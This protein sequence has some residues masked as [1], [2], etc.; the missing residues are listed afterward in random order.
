LV[1]MSGSLQLK[2]SGAQFAGQ[3]VNILSGRASLMR[4][5][6]ACSI[7]G[8]LSSLFCWL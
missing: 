6:Q 5:A 1:A 8:L 2:D 7:H 4:D 3:P